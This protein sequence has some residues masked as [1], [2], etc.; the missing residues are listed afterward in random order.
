[1]G[2]A[3]VARCPAKVGRHGPEDQTGGIGVSDIWVRNGQR[4]G[5]V[6]DM[7]T[8][9]DQHGGGL[10]D[11]PRA[12]D[13]AESELWCDSSQCSYRELRP[14]ARRSPLSAPVSTGR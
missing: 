1:M 5:G 4:S 14:W 9:R 2:W 6:Q 8:L 13:R 12:A 10:P 7:N 11:L 3:A